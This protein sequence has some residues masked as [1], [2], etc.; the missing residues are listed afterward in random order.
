[1]LPRTLRNFS[2]FVEGI[3]YG[4]RCTELT[5]PSLNIT[6]EE[7]RAGG[8]DAP[9]EIDMGQ[10]AMVASFV[11][12]EYEPEIMNLVGLYDQDGTTI[13]ARGA[14]QR[15]G[16]ED[17]VPITAVMTGGIKS[18]DPGSFEAG[19]L[20]EATFEMAV[21]TYTLTIGGDEVYNIDAI[22]MTRVINGTDQLQS[23][24]AAIGA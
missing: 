16:N 14:L 5:L 9:V 11:V 7:Y 19:A 6:T 13:T 23:I 21:R 2:L 1:M 22:N 12:A 4:G 3:G 24:R 18:F 20:T 15:N 17:A 10:E 8:I